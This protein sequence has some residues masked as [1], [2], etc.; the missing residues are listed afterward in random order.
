MLKDLQPILAQETSLQGSDVSLLD[1]L[2]ARDQRAIR[3]KSLLETYQQPVLSLTIN[4][5]GG[6]KRN[7]L[8]DYVFKQALKALERRFKAENITPTEQKITQANT[9]NE[10]IFSVNIP[11]LQLKQ[12][13]IALESTTPLARLWDM[14]VIDRNGKPISRADLGVAPRQCLICPENAKICARQRSHSMADLMAALQKLVQQ[15]IYS[16]YL[17]NQACQALCA[18]AMLTP[19]PGLVDAKSQGAHKDMDAALLV[20]SAQSLTPFF[21][22]CVQLGMNTTQTMPSAVFPQ[23]RLIGI[24]AEKAM[25]SAT[26]GVNTHKGAIFA[27]ALC[28]CSLG[29]LIAQQDYQPFHLQL[30]PLCENVAALSA[31]VTAE[32]SKVTEP[33]TA[34]EKLFK[35]YGVT[36]ARGEAEQGFPLL[37]QLWQHRPTF[38]HIPLRQQPYYWLLYLMAHNTD[39]NLLHRGGMAGLTLVQQQAQQLLN[40]SLPQN[41]LKT[42]LHYFDQRCIQNNL[43]PG[44]SADIL[45]LALFL[46]RLGF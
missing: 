31:G 3:Q 2:N 27:F 38:A 18:E 45:A 8:L 39:T 24:Q 13:C 26:K 30:A 43:S 17:A 5:M 34:G 23:L 21:A 25:F 33:K 10:A 37:R 4:A 42:E 7:A 40:Q 11:A 46:D 41:Q 6:V 9:G 35:T 29:R 19:K 1:L 20:K 44:G 15:D 32:L 36:G 16:E 28:L 14:D 22:Q 12:L